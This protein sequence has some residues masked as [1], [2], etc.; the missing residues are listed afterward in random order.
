MDNSR[1][2]IPHKKYSGQSVVISCRL[3]KNMLEDI[4]AVAE[5]TGRTRNEV[6][7]LSLE[8]ALDHL[9]ENKNGDQ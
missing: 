7:T 2:F 6:I 9:D 8:Y 1:F 3:F 5:K 4:D